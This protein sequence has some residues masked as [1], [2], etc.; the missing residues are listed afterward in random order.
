VFWKCANPECE[1]CF[2]Y[3]QGRLFRFSI[4]Q[5]NRKWRVGAHSVRHFW[6]CRLCA[7]TFTLSY[8][9]GQG[10]LIG[11]RFHVPSDREASRL[12]AAA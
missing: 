1:V 11:H 8:R 3:R 12:I 5:S 4:G 10:V 2:D 6:L 7:E 9:E